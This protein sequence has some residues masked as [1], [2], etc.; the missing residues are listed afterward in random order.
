MAPEDHG[1]VR[2]IVRDTGS[3][4]PL[5]KQAMIF[6]AFTQ[7]DSSTTRKFGGTGLGLAI[8]AKL[9][10]MMEGR[11]WVESDGYSGSTFSFTA[12]LNAVA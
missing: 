12:Q 9:V 5:A 10:E 7:A 8:V 4:V 1:L 6:D 3:G 2:F 11:I